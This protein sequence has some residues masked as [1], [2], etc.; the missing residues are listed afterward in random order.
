MERIIDANTVFGFWPKRNIDVSLKKL[1]KIMAEHKVK[2]FL[3]LSIKGILY[4]YEEGNEETLRISRK[5]PEL[6]PIATVDLRK[7]FGKRPLVK[8]LV[9][10]GFKA[11]RL[12]PDLQGWP[13][14]YQPFFQIVE[15]TEANFPL[16]T[17]VTRQG[18][19][20]EI[21]KITE[22]CRTPIILTGITEFFY[23]EALAVMRS[24]K[25]IYLETHFFD[26]PDVYEIFVREVGAERIIFG[27]FSPFHYFSSS[28]LT[29]KRAEISEN[30]KE[31]IFGKNIE[32]LLK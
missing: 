28:F 15:E 4:D 3:S 30:E 2:Q 19:I 31:L 10:Q 23:S 20:T 1:L 32:R 18:M 22:G 5:H 9:N 25:N 12:F 8:E 29:L 13:V 24:H 16:M 11:L 6:I 14:N 26:T 17:S 21:G 27:S 7:Y